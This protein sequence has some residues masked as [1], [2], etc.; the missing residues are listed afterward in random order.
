MTEEIK[1]QDE[2]QPPVIIPEIITEIPKA[3]EPKRHMKTVIFNPEEFKQL[4]NIC[5]ARITSG[6]TSD[7]N[8]FVRQLMDYALNNRWQKPDGYVFARPENST[9]NLKNTFENLHL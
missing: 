2:T 8:H 9:V 6:I 4:E 7:W 5:Q 1:Q 3:A